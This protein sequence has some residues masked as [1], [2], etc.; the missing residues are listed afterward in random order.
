MFQCK[1]S[2]KFHYKNADLYI[3]SR[4]SLALT[5]NWMEAQLLMKIQ[6][7]VGGWIIQPV[8]SFPTLSII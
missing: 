2:D 1:T 8:K 4:L 3:L 7:K 6:G 5:Q